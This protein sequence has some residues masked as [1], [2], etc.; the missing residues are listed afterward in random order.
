MQNLE[1]LSLII[2]CFSTFFMTGLIWQIQVNH[3]PSFSYVESSQFSQFQHFH[4][5]SITYVVMPVMLMEV[6]FGVLITFHLAEKFKAYQHYLFLNLAL[7]I[8]IWLSTWFFS[9][10]AHNKL[11]NRKDQKIIDRLVQTNWPRTILWTVRSF[12]LL[13]LLTQLLIS[14]Q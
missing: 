2:H 12:I 13:Y 1:V 6:F 5:R 3:Y 8:L 4:M 14:G 9:V 11:I 10:P 7:L